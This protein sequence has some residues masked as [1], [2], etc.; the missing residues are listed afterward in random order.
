MVVVFFFLM[1]RRP[2]R[3][4]LFPYTTLFRSRPLHFDRGPLAE[5]VM[6]QVRLQG[7]GNRGRDSALGLLAGGRES[8][9]IRLQPC[10]AFLLRPRS[11]PKEHP[12]Q[13]DATNSAIPRPNYDQARGLG[14]EVPAL[15]PLLHTGFGD[16]LP[17]LGG[18][19]PI[20]Q[21]DA[22]P[23]AENTQ[24]DGESLPYWAKFGS[25]SGLDR[26]Q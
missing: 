17:E 21:R 4:T 8:L 9:A 13:G 19:L 24:E 18:E 22:L 3:S 2:P 1:I 5:L 11:V 7:L 16:R 23:R 6:A 10:E 14:R 15:R 20:G 26:R 25:I 12:L